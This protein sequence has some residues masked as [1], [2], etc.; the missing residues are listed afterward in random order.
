MGIPIIETRL[1]GEPVHADHAHA[2]GAQAGHDEAFERGS[3]ALGPVAFTLLRGEFTAR[4]KHRRKRLQQLSD[5]R[6]AVKAELALARRAAISSHEHHRASYGLLMWEAIGVFAEFCE[7]LAALVSARRTSES[8][9]GDLGS[10]L[11]AFKAP[12]TTILGGKEFQDMSWWREQLSLDAATIAAIR[13]ELEPRL[14]RAYD[15]IVSEADAR[16]GVAVAAVASMY[17]EPLHRVAQRRKHAFPYV[18]PWI[19]YV[20]SPLD[21]D[22]EAAAQDI[23]RKGGIALLDQR[24][25][26]GNPEQWQ[27]FVAADE[28]ALDALLSACAD[29]SWLI[30]VLAGAINSRAENPTGR[31]IVFNDVWRRDKSV[32]DDAA[33]TAV[34]SGYPAAPLAAMITRAVQDE[35]RMDFGRSGGQVP[36]PG[37]NQPCWCGSGKKYKRCHGR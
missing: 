5:E 35:V 8:H 23:M 6:E 3:A 13:S 20:W 14:K 19:G 9:A 33:I 26:K 21:A 36:T 18:S 12:A 34:V 7:Q 17:D 2:E 37:R 16:L 10:E 24:P 11:L 31:A 30:A 22:S 28:P 32:E 27:M 25:A 4:V 15:E 29:A 1:D